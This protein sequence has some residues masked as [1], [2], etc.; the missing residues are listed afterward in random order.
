MVKGAGTWLLLGLFGACLCVLGDHLH[1]T[2]DVLV[3]TPVSWWGQAWW[4]W[5]EF[6]I[7]TLAAVGTAARFARGLPAPRRRFFADLVF[8]CG[9]YAY[10]SF[11]PWDRPNVTTFVLVG[12]F[13]VRVLAED[14]PAW[15]VWHSL[16]LAL[17]GPLCEAALSWVGTFHYVHPDII[18]VPRWLPGIYLAAGLASGEMAL[19]MRQ[20][21]KA[22][23][24]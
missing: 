22:P 1:A 4:V 16:Q 7:G 9:A 24:A 23:S 12:A 11:A 10:T 14:R 18:G 6:I 13:V 20:S 3:Y 8:F 19:Q 15:L 21:S 17:V 5:P 2:H